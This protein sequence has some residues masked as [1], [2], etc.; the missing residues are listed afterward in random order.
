[1]SLGFIYFIFN[2]MFPV[3]TY[4]IGKAQNFNNNIIMMDF[5]K[6]NLQIIDRSEFVKIFKNNKITGV[7]ITYELLKAIHFNDKYP[8]LNNIYISDINLQKCMIVQ[9]NE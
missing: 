7:K 6:E 8:Q 4:K 3:N 9:N 1:M 2:P 5:S